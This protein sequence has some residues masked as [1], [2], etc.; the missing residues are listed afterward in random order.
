MII[1]DIQ[2]S[3]EC[4]MALSLVVQE[5]FSNLLV[6]TLIDVRMTCHVGCRIVFSLMSIAVK[7]VC[8]LKMGSYICLPSESNN[9]NLLDELSNYFIWFLVFGDS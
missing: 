7:E 9:P 4:Y 3:C 5:T 2:Y 1:R 8:H 6:V